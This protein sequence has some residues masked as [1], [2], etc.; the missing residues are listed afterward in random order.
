MAEASEVKVL[1][2]RITEIE[3]EREEQRA[4]CTILT[5]RLKNAETALGVAENQNRELRTKFIAVKQQLEVLS[6]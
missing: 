3:I 4:R 6:K 2:T 5:E 1:R